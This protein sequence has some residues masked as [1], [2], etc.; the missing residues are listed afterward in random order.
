MADDLN[1]VIGYLLAY[2]KNSG[3][4]FIRNNKEHTAQEA[5]EHMRKKYDHFKEK[6]HSPEDFIA[7]AGTK[8]LLSGRPYRVRL[9]NGK[10]M[11]SKK[12][13]EVALEEY[14]RNK[15]S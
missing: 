8:S 15:S 1:D 14:R 3:V 2:V 13:L 5:E 4:V 9:K 11:L 10:T 12:W 7:L 6:I